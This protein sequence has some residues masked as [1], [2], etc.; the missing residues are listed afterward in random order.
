M[1]LVIFD[2][3]GVIVST[4]HLHYRAWKM[5][6]EDY[7]LIFDE[8]I[9]S[10][11]RG[12][13]RAESLQIILD[14]NEKAVE[15][16]AFDQM[17]KEKNDYYRSSLEMLDKTWILPGVEDLVADLK[18]SGIKV[19][20]GSS[21]RNTPK[22]LEQ[23][24]MGDIWDEIVDG[25]HIKRSKPD[26]EVFIKSADKLKVD[27]SEC[28]V[29][30]DAQAGVDAARAAGMKVVGVGQEPLEDVDLHLTSLKGVEAKL[31][32]LEVFHG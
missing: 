28:L 19:A 12:V 22:I 13:S 5:L 27:Y 21:S 29:F 8:T 9:N 24:G 2:L 26:P 18:A 20:I 16:Q 14:V 31:L 6:V 25:N 23:I 11:L 3:D 10:R 30:E 1:K 7:N 32:M 17:L 4:D 15:A